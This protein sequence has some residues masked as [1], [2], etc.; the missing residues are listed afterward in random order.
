M[1][2]GIRATPT[3]MFFLDGKKLDELR[4]GDAN[5]L[6]TQIDLLL[7]QAYPPHPHTSLSIPTIQA[8]SLNP[9]IFSQVPAFETV[10][11]KLSSFIDDASWPTSVS[12][13]KD[14][15]KAVLL[16][17]VLPYLKTRFRSAP[18]VDVKT[19]PS[20]TPAILT[21]WMQATSALALALP[22]ES[23][24]PLVDMWRLAFLDPA[25]GSWLAAL[26]PTNPPTDPIS[27]FLTKTIN[28]LDNPSKGSRN[29]VLTVLRMLCN[30]F[31]HTTL[32]HQLLASSL[33]MREKIT[34]DVLVPS[35][36]HSDG[37][38]RTAAASLAFDVSTVLQKSRVEAVKSGRGIGAYGAAEGG[39][40][41][42]EVE[43]VS[44]VIEAL[45]REK[46]NEEVVHRLTAA[47]AF[48]LRLSPQYESQ[49]KSLLEV[50]QARKLLRGKLVKGSGWNADG[51]IGKKEIRKLVEEVAMKLC[52]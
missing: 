18:P 43:M 20:A 16:G 52:P 50:L 6:K 37:L 19:L 27:V 35:L 21:S 8:L 32:S 40:A 41:D 1:E 36:L 31:S 38:V 10:V 9:I 7:F 11:S 34:A 29:Y 24:F 42:W 26:T 23:L 46:E 17:T 45:D 39:F 51:G 4:G 28:A 2:W 25:V 30:A 13:S 48:F 33:T 44:A 5:E 3:F 15:T 14:Q 22:V 47:L 49:I 12:Q